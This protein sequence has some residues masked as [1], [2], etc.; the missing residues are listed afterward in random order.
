MGKFITISPD[1]KTFISGYWRNFGTTVWD[2]E[3]KEKIGYLGRHEEEV[4]CL[5][6]TPDGQKVISGS[7]DGTF[8]V[9]DFQT[10]EIILTLNAGLGSVYSVAVTPD[11]KYIISGYYHG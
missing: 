3:L 4:L 9:W 1:G 5:A 7:Y 10:K 2:L 6:I 8:V 11:N